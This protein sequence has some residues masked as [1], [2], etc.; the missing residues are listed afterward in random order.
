MSS[1]SSSSSGR[2][3][4]SAVQL[5]SV[6]HDCLKVLPQGA[7]CLREN[8]RSPLSVV[9][10]SG[11]ARKGKSTRA[12]A[13][14]RGATVPPNPPGQAFQTSESSCP[15][16][17]GVWMYPHPVRRDGVDVLIIDTE[18]LGAGDTSRHSEMVTIVAAISS[19]FMFIQSK[20]LQDDFLGPVAEASVCMRR[21]IANDHG[22]E[23]DWPVLGVYLT[24]GD[25]ALQ[26]RKRRG[27]GTVLVDISEEEYLENFLQEEHQDGNRD[28]RSH[29]CNR[30]PDRLLVR[31]FPP[32][33]EDKALLRRGQSGDSEFFQQLDA[34]VDR[35]LADAAE[36]PKKT[37]NR[38]WSGNQLADMIEHFVASVNASGKMDVMAAAEQ[39]LL[40][41]GQDHLACLIRE[42]DDGLTEEIMAHYARSGDRLSFSLQG[43]IR[44]AK[45]TIRNKL[46]TFAKDNGL[47]PGVLERLHALMEQQV[48]ALIKR[49]AQE[50]E[51][52]DQERRAQEERRLAQERLQEEKR[53]A[54]ERAEEERRKAQERLEQERMQREREKRDE[55]DR[56]RRLQREVEENRQ[57][58]AA[59]A[60][61][62]Y[63]PPAPQ[64][65][66]AP[67]FD[68]FAPSFSS[69]GGHS[70]RSSSSSGS[71]TSGRGIPSSYS[72]HSVASN[73][74]QVFEGPRGGLFTINSHGNRQS[75]PRS[76]GRRR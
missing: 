59:M 24:D 16:T 1:S 71:S 3:P 2:S 44:K 64:Y 15:Q 21:M 52:K 31:E 5:I 46:N 43:P 53:R 50:I 51:N 55:D 66:P 13:L 20:S 73:G 72:P 74:R 19:L 45:D 54:N 28:L 27:R 25:L 38:H 76:G 75:L 70:M 60:I 63:A 11:R 14:V 42:V 48:D 7:R 32:D 69:P 6:E 37:C 22:V 62:S 47:F 33:E 29:I 30:F 12:N 34:N 10:L 4:A 68:S 49:Q 41:E 56:I 9:S 61:S 57:R 58:M 67:S 40:R 26:A 35:I 39:V 23:L 36:N 17:E 8:F 18:G 65:C